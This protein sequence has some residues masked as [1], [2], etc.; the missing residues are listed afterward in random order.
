MK[1]M[2]MDPCLGMLSNIN[3][4]QSRVCVSYIEV[5]ASLSKDLDMFPWVDWVDLGTF[6]VN[7]NHHNHALAS[8]R[9]FP[10]S[11]VRLD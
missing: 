6:I 1:E 11:A 2:I 9:I 4:H 3:Y 7:E 8:P 10:V 5:P